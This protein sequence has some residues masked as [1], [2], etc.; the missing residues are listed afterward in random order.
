MTSQPLEFFID[1]ASKGNPG[2]AGIGVVV[3]RGKETIR[4]ISE[5]IGEAT[6]NTAEYR[7]LLRALRE[8]VGLRAS[9]VRIFSDS[10]LLCRQVNGQYRVKDPHLRLLF[11]EATQL[12]SRFALISVEH[13]RREENSGA[14]RL[15]T[16]AVKEHLKTTH[17]SGFGRQRVAAP[18][19]KSGEE[20]PGSG[21]QA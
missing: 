17:Q 9:S 1:G 13:I 15:A 2:H 21:G 6:N 4:T 10:E 11:Q 16:L 14:D 12:L 5:Y 19:T 18:L 20:S 3:T 8:A 7:A